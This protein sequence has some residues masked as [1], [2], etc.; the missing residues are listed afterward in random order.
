MWLPDAFFFFEFT[1]KNQSSII[2]QKLS[3]SL[4]LIF[5]LDVS[6]S[7]N[8]MDFKIK[9]AS[10]SADR[11][12]MLDILRGKL[13]ETY[14]QEFVFVVNHFKTGN[15]YAWFMG[16]VARKDGKELRIQYDKNGEWNGLDCCHVE[17]LFK[18]SGGKWYIVESGEFSTDL[19]Y[20]GISNRYP[21]APRGIFNE[22]AY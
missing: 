14:H 6:Y 16:Q 18:K 17:T 13:Y 22:G 21:Y 9:T 5:I 19:W 10:N 15:G 8:I 12:M 2:M 20:A 4:L 11:T 3:L 1:L 7:Q